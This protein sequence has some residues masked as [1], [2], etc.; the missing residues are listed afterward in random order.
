MTSFKF[1]L[2]YHTWI[3]HY[4]HKNKGCDYSVG[5]LNLLF[6]WLHQ[7]VQVQ[8]KTSYSRSSYYTSDWIS[9]VLNSELQTYLEEG[10][11]IK[12]IKR[13]DR[14]F[15]SYIIYQFTRNLLFQW[16]HQ[17]LQVRNKTSYSLSSY[18]T[19][20]VI[21]LVTNLFREKRKKTQTNKIND[22]ILRS[23]RRR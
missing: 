12:Q 22:R 7:S 5:M 11:I 17:L 4:E 13:K 15:I 23:T 3:K 19:S 16:L 2:W 8:N 10:K 6:Q 20:D 9:L 18:H 21:S 1:S 14:S